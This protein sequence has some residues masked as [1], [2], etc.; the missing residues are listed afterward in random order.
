MTITELEQLGKLINRL[1]ELQQEPSYYRE[2]N[3]SGM[4]SAHKISDQTGDTATKSADIDIEIGETILAIR[5]TVKSLMSYFSTLNAEL[6]Q[7][8]E[9]RYIRCYSYGQI[10]YTTGRKRNYIYTKITDHIRQLE[11]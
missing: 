7:M 11:K 5:E 9:L 6:G 8:M 3:L 10:A 2:L 1:G 4:P